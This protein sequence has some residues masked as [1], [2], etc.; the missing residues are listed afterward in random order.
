[1]P[2]YTVKLSGA[3]FLESVENFKRI[4]PDIFAKHFMVEGEDIIGE[5]KMQVP[6]DTGTLRSTGHVRR[7][8]I[9]NGKVTVEMGFGGPAAS[10]ALFVH[11]DFFVNHTVGA[12][13]YL[14]VPFKTALPQIST[15]LAK[16]I[17]REMRKEFRRKKGK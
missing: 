1:M 14:E 8:K 13:K 17:R 16:R 4:L 12:A 3:Q 7:P 11:E 10:Y 9:A 2:K 15:R 5:A 6:V